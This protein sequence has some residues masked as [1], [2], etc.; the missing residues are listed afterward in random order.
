MLTSA[1][2]TDR[3]IEASI[4]IMEAFVEMS[5]IIRQNAGLLPQQ[6]IRLLAHRQDELQ[7]E[8]KDIKD[9]MITKYTIAGQVVKMPE[10]KSQLLP[11]LKRERYIKILSRLF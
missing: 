6:E 9:N 2:H 1:L 8:V 11:R 4:L 5:H 7:D 10:E 3:A